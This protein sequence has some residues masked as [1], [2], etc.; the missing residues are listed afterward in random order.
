M[1][2]FLTQYG[3]K[4]VDLPT[5]LS[6]IGYLNQYEKREVACMVSCRNL[7]VCLY[8][9]LGT[10]QED[11]VTAEPYFRTIGQLFL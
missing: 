3:V 8:S 10:V 5:I 9:A 4:M 11:L 7:M 1:K 6:I 2:L